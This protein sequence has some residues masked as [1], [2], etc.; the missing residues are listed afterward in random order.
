MEPRAMQVSPLSHA[1]PTSPGLRTLH[2]P[3]PLCPHQLPMHPVG[4]P[5]ETHNHGA[6][7]PGV[8]LSPNPSQKQGDHRPPSSGTQQHS[9]DQLTVEVTLPLVSIPQASLGLSSSLG[10]FS[11]HPTLPPFPPLFLG[12]PVP[13]VAQ[14]PLGGLCAYRF[15]R[16]VETGVT[17]TAL[18]GPGTVTSMGQ[19]HHR[20]PAG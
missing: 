3:Q 14:R 17:P 13:P 8:L 12:G 5:S 9:W 16:P 19:G 20:L 7:G 2:C 15:C 4:L 11:W 10:G 18:W 1:P 6:G